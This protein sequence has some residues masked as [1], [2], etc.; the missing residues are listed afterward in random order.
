MTLPRL[1]AL[2]I[3][4]GSFLLFLVQPIIAKELLPQF[5]GSASVWLTCL[6]FFQSALLLGYAGADRLTASVPARLQSALVVVL[7]LMAAATLPIVPG[8][9][10][11]LAQTHPALGVLAALALAVGLPYVLVSATS[12]VIQSW[13]A[14]CMPGR[15]PYPLFALS[16]LASML[17]LFGYPLAVEPWVGTRVQ[18]YAWSA[19]YL[20]WAALVGI[21]AFRARAGTLPPAPRTEDAGRATPFEAAPTGSRYGE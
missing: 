13:Y 3:F 20:V 6:V 11:S 1:F 14:R 9:H 2:T 19:G 10:G 5:G 16:N 17:A 21:C 4:C 18:A 12:P 8:V 15:S 7:L